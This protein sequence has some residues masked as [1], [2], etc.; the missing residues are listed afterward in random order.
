M[1]RRLLIVV[2][3]LALGYVGLAAMNDVGNGAM[4]DQMIDSEG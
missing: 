1:T 2:A 4:R 3:A